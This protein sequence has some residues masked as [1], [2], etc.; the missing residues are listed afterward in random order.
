MQTRVTLRMVVMGGAIVREVRTTRVVG[1]KL[2]DEI[3]RYAGTGR[4][5][6]KTI[7]DV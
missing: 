1:T 6:I 5:N 4:G 2:D 7:H 3:N